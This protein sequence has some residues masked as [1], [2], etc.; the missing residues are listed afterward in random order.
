[1]FPV[2][3]KI[4]IEFI[5]IVDPAFRFEQIPAADGIARI[6]RAQQTDAE[7]C[8]HTEPFIRIAVGCR[9]AQFI[10]FAD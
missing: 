2:E 8:H 1:M 3:G 5:G 6:V 9:I 7:P 10:R 4:E